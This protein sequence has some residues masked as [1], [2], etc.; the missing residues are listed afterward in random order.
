MFL[1]SPASNPISDLQVKRVPRFALSPRRGR[2]APRL[3]GAGAPRGCWQ[4]NG[5]R[6]RAPGSGRGAGSTVPGRSFPCTVPKQ[7]DTGSSALPANRWSASCLPHQAGSGL[8]QRRCRPRRCLR[9]GLG[10]SVVFRADRGESPCFLQQV[11]VSGRLGVEWQV[12]SLLQAGGWT[13]KVPDC[14]WLCRGLGAVLQWGREP[15][16][17]QGALRA[18]CDS[19]P[20]APCCKGVQDVQSCNKCVSLIY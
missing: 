13:V 6:L 20:L 4:H 12:S 7:P 19:V 2:G 18:P 8:R 15:E 9:P 14:V 5:E 11:E 16:G 17:R 1:T 10:Q 3:W